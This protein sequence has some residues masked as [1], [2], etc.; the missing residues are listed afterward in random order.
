MDHSIQHGLAISIQVFPHFRTDPLHKDIGVIAGLAYI[1]QD[2]AGSH[3]ANYHSAFYVIRK[4][5]IGKVLQIV[6]DS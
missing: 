5:P 6:I 2:A 3:I 1:G 4:R